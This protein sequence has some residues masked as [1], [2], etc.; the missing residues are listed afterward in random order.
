MTEQEFGLF[1]VDHDTRTVRGILVPWDELSRVSQTGNKPMKFRPGGVAL[2]RD[3]TVVGLNRE[4]DR[5]APMGRLN[6]AE[7]VDAGLFAEFQIADTDEGDQW[8]A[9]H[10][11]LVR[12]SPELKDI[13]TRGE[14]ATAT[15]TGAALCQDGAWASAG[16]FA[17]GSVLELDDEPD[18]DEEDEDEDDEPAPADPDT[19]PDSEPDEQEEDAVAEATAPN[20]MLAAR[21]TP[22]APAIT[23]TKNGFF[24]A[25]HH[26]MQSADASGLRPYLEAPG[27]VDADGSGMFALTDIPYDGAGGLA[28]T[29]AIPTGWLG[30]LW[31]G[32]TFARTVV[33]LLTQATLAGIKA[34]GFVW[35]VKPV[36]AA[37]AG[38][39]A[40]IASNTP[41]TVPKDFY[42]QRYAGGHD[43]AR[44]YYD[45][46][47]TEVINSYVQAMVDSY[48]RLS[49][50]YAL[51]QLKAGATAYTPV[52][53]AVNK[54]L[55]AVVD[56]ALAVV[57]AGAVPSFAIVATNVFR[58]ILGTPQSSALEYFDAAVGLT[59]A[60]GAGFQIVP[61]SRLA[62]GEIIVG[63]RQAATSWEL[64]GVPIRVSAPDL[65]KGG[66]DEAFFGYIAV[67]VTYPAAV[68]K[69]TLTLPLTEEAAVEEPAPSSK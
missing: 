43:L 4:H 6:K 16:L 13:R 59:S 52:T 65:V 9:D 33:P 15:L 23:L 10:G 58:D 27:A 42:A 62:T 45:F 8:L 1:T 25:M 7:P 20:T 38:N 40:A 34:S 2:P 37:W 61:D 22:R 46:N 57:A 5:F 41:T 49:D 26:A 17:I 29:A 39:K 18:E 35:G 44:E 68:V 28:A 55:L 51:A 3:V 47:I 50:G 54:G 21:R 66:I 30:E 56:G 48:A 64:P 67:G 24:S 60:S 12:L 53:S 36:M 31:Q 19:E 14:Y 69:A 32:V 11:E 63:A